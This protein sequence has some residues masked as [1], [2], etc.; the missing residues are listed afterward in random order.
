MLSGKR[1]GCLGRLPGGGLLAEL[2]LKRMKRGGHTET[3]VGEGLGRGQNSRQ[4]EQYLQ[5]QRYD[6]QEPQAG[7]KHRI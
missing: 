5:R 3:V 7:L 6:G 2:N 4:R 1:E